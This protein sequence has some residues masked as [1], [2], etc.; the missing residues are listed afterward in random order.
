MAR[1]LARNLYTSTPGGDNTLTVRNGRRALAR[2]LSE[3]RRLDQLKVHSRIKGVKEEVEEMIDDLLFTDVAQSV[4]CSDKDL[5]FEGK[6]R[7][8]FARINRA[9]LGTSGIA[10]NRGLKDG[11]S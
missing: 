1:G 5:A 3:E 10:S 9:E 7:K 6:N 2:A 11:L 4:F 8:V